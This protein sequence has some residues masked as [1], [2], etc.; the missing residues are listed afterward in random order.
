VH[1]VLQNLFSFVCFFDICKP[2][3]FE[4]SLMNLFALIRNV[5]CDYVD[6]RW[7]FQISIHVAMTRIFVWKVSC[8]WRREL[9]CSRLI[10]RGFYSAFCCCRNICLI[11]SWVDNLRKNV[12]YVVERLIWAKFG[13]HEFISINF[14]LLAD[15]F[16]F[17]TRRVGIE[18]RYWLVALVEAV[19]EML[20][21]RMVENVLPCLVFLKNVTFSRT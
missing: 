2:R 14:Y 3:E 8:V 17:G 4:R 7:N 1:S 21:L 9:N 11:A 12:D 6:R 15:V 13:R 5:R 20:M 10:V 18:D 16:V 19:A